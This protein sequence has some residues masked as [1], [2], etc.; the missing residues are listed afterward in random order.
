MY[1]RLAWDMITVA[2]LLG[3][4]RHDCMRIRIFQSV[5]L[6]RAAA[7]CQFLVGPGVRA[8]PSA[9]GDGSPGA[10]RV[11]NTRGALSRRA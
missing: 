6:V 1:C 7:E 3:Y 10:V 9:G 8:L 4:T 2:R 5:G 11:L